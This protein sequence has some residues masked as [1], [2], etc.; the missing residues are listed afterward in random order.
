MTSETTTQS[1]S[2]RFTTPMM[3]QFARL[4]AENPDAILLFRCGDF[5]ETYCEDAEEAGRLLN[6]A[7][8]RKGAGADGDVAMAGVPFHAIDGYLAKLVR[9]GRHVAIA[10]QTEDPKKAKGLVRREIVRVVTPGTAIEEAILEDGANNYIACLVPGKSGEWGV[11]LADVSTGFF[12][13]TEVAAAD[14]AARLTDELAGLEARE[15]LLPESADASILNPLLAERRVSITRRP[16]NDFRAANARG[17]LLDHLRVQ[18]L[19]GFGAGDLEAGVCAAGGLLRYLR[20]TQKTSIGHIRSLRVHHGREGMVLD[21]VTQRS[22]ELVR[23]LHGGGREGT[24]LEVLDRTVTP[25]GAR[26][27]RRWILQPLAGV[28]EIAERLEAVDELVRSGTLRRDLAAALKNVRDVE[29]ITG[30]A[31][32]GTAGPRDLAALRQS[33]A[34]LPALKALLGVRSSPLLLREGA[35]ITPLDGLTDRLASGLAEEPPARVADGGAIRD[36]HD[37]RLD[38]LRSVSRDSKT[39]IAEFRAREAQ[40][41][42]IDKLRIGYNKVFGYY[43]ELTHAQIRTLPGGETPGDYVRKQTLA[44]GE[45]YITPELKEREDTILHA[46]ERSLALE[47]ELFDGLRLAVAESAPELLANAEIVARADCLL[48]LAETAIEHGYARPVVTEEDVLEVRD[49]RHPVL[50]ALQNDPPFVPNDVCLASGECQLGLITGPNM[51]GKSTF[52]RQVALIALMAHMGSFVPAAEARIGLLD[53]IFTRVGAMDHLARGQSTF[54]VEMT[55]TANILRNATSR[56]LVI[57]D[58]IGRGTSTYDGLSIAWA[59]CEFL[60]NTEGQAPKT[61]FATHYHELTALDRALPRIRNFHVAVLEQK[62]RIV[63][64]FKVVPGATDRSYGVHAAEFAGVPPEVVGR[65]REILA[66]LER[67]E[68]VAPRLAESGG[69]GTAGPST[70]RKASILPHAEKWDPQTSLFDMAPENAAVER[71]RLLDPN[72]LTPLEALAIL[73]ELKSLADSENPR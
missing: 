70:R 59:V 28:S 52:I 49:G 68:A 8:T 10:E 23:N 62:D 6:I 18:S 3:Q 69:S 5:Y 58:E 39:W 64:L 9:L 45:R 60:H 19:E 37:A 1:S 44:N 40:R 2:R 16:D 32:A 67:G 15:I 71:L 36:G 30:R 56:S 34:S 43:I 50:E 65:A 17:L 24:L 51:A 11:G 41:T 21:A 35:S 61:L 48:S 29:R 54:L 4:K 66:G 73:S 25:M 27:L 33:L 47:H 14:A 20:D 53:R 26:M 42:G 13:L 57:L 72:R 31:S 38:E 55:E 46:E 7:V 12:A 22:L 63:F